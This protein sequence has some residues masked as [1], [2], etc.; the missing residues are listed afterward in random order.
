[1]S[2]TGAKRSVTCMARKKLVITQKIHAGRSVE[3][4][5]TLVSTL[6]S[7]RDADLLDESHR[8]ESQARR[9][10]GSVG[11]TFEDSGVFNWGQKQT[12]APTGVTRLTST[13]VA[14]LCLGVLHDDRPRDEVGELETVASTATPY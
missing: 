1:M 14:K 5:S 6:S 4:A 2:F 13:G 7:P 9:G 3:I 8:Q 10:A 11:R 12:D